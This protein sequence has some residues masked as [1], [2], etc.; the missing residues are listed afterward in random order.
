MK[1]CFVIAI[2][3]AA[4]LVSTADTISSAQAKDHIGEAATVCGMVADAR[5]LETG[6]HVTFLNFD[7]PYPEQTFTA[8]LPAE[9]RSKFGTPEKEYKGREICVTGKIQ[10]Y[11]G[12][13]EI[14]LTDPQQIKAAA[15]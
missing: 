9:N 11:R 5:Y 13:P 10:E 1:T 14:V 3:I 8:F 15:K 2:L 12:N 4:P 6:S 7:K